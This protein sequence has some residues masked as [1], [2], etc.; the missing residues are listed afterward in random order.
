MGPLTPE[1]WQQ[2]SA[3]LDEALELDGRARSAFLDRVCAGDEELRARIEGL[4]VADADSNGFLEAPAG[5]HL[6]DLVPPVSPDGPSAG[7]LIGPYRV[8]RELARGGMGEVCLAERADG[9]FDQCVALKLIRQ[10]MGTGELHRRFLAERRILARLNHPNIARLLDGGITADGQPW[11]AMEYVDGQPL[12]AWCEARH[13]TLAARLALFRDV[14]E[15]VRYAHQSL[16][17]HRDLKPSNLLVTPPGQ[18]KLL[19]FGIAKLLDEAPVSTEDGQQSPATRTEL[20]LLT[21]EYAAPE[22]I[23]GEPVTTATDVYALGAVLYELLTGQRA[24]RFERNTLAEMERVVCETEPTRPSQAAPAARRRELS[25]DLDTIVLK[26]LEKSPSRRYPSVEALLEDLRR[27]DDGLPIR[28][29]P[30]SLAYRLHKFIRRHRAGAAMSLLAA[31]LACAGL[32]ATVYQARAKAREAEKAR[33]VKDFLVSLFQVADP[34]QSRGR[35]ITARELLD[36]GVRRVDS[37]LGRQPAMQE[38]LLGILGTIHRELG[39]YARADSLFARAV[40]AAE[41]AYGPD[42]PEVAAR[43]TD[44]GTSLKELGE[45]A[46]AESVYQ[47]ALAIRRRVLGPEHVDVAY[48]MGE[49]ASTFSDEGKYQPAESLFRAVLALDLRHRG[50]ADLEVATDLENLGVLLGERDNFAGADSAYRAALRIQKRHLDPNHPKVINILGNIATNLGDMGRYVE[51]ESLHR[52]VLTAR[53]RLFP[54]GHP[55]VA[56]SL[57]TLAA[58]LEQTGRW[59]EA[60][61]LEVEALAQRRRLLGPDH[62]VTMQT[63]NNLAIV[64]YRMG[65]LAGAEPAFREALRTWEAKLGPDH[66]Y[67][68]RARN[69]LGAVLSEAGKYAEAESLLRRSLAASVRT[70]GDS[71]LDAAVTRRT[72]GVLLHRTGRLR[73]AER[74]LRMAL[75]TYRSELPDSHPRAA[76]ALTGLGQV[77]T[78]RGRAREAE[79]LLREALA[80]REAKL[81]PTD[82]RIPETREALGLALLAEGRRQEGASLL[83]EACEAFDASRWGTRQSRECRGHL[84]PRLPR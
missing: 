9:Q 16:V 46:A 78:D 65:D 56:W 26:A 44:R 80:I 37:A 23:R 43:L 32:G 19:D 54:E 5:H 4:L 2:V 12:M 22:Q 82:L 60:E 59:A 49:L 33:Q 1:R 58:L 7:T 83:R 73:E 51:A 53:R 17:V 35:E 20:R 10:G 68:D 63:L 61:S 25:G 21:P 11:F 28:A 77:L 13:A 66:A 69:N 34:A 81:D 6:P 48:T 31:V 75:A 84:T 76:E 70:L 30:D 14:C 40:V 45:L 8:L 15:A 42:H 67:T 18:V 64:R 55:D 62:P 24:H 57:H 47:R 27:Y 3:I 38:E 36:R 29:R 50:P 39:L 52:Q 71:A 72:L 74:S 79:P 41:R